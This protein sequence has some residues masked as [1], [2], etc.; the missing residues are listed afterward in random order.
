MDP[1]LTEMF[2]VAMNLNGKNEDQSRT[3]Y[4]QKKFM[5]GCD[6]TYK[7]I[8]NQSGD[9]I[10]SSC[11]LVLEERFMQSQ[12]EFDANDN[13]VSIQSSKN[14]FFENTMMSTIISGSKKKGLM[15]MLHI[16]TS[17]N[18]KESYRNKEFCEVERLCTGLKT[19]ANIASQA[20]HYF[21]DLCKLK[22]FRGENRKAM[23][24]CCIIRS[25]STNKVNRTVTEIC[26]VVNVQKHIFT[27]NLKIYE[28]LIKVK[29]FNERISDEIYRHLQSLGVKNADVFKMSNTVIEKQKEMLRSKEFQGKSPKVLLAIIL[30]SMGF[31]KKMIC[32]ALT[33]SIT[34]F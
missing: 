32:G 22:V 8:D 23:M 9:V 33:V 30:R 2:D 27:K 6:E 31:D 19:T 5:C 28:A 29:L 10:C 15:N 21:N 13:F 4:I 18:Q 11:G 12:D 24:A 34:A 17:V 25:F 26:E 3:P 7:V 20:K 1:D 14:E 16:Q